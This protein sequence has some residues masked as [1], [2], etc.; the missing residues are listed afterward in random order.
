M[1]S[2]KDQRQELVEAALP[3]ILDRRDEGSLGMGN[4][5]KSFLYLSVSH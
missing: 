4:V 3:T 1:D 2:F 5:A